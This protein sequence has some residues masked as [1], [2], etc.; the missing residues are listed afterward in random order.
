[1]SEFRIVEGV[2][3]YW[4]YHWS[5]HPKGIKSLCGRQTMS[6][7][8][9]ERLWGLKGHLNERYCKECERMKNA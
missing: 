2:E 7:E 8:L 3:G 4:H 9:P 1:M 6:C 5:D